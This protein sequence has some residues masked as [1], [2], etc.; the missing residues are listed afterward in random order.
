D[1]M[2][3]WRPNYRTTALVDGRYSIK[4]YLDSVKK[5]W[6]DY[7]AQGGHPLTAF[8]HFCYHQPFTRQAVKGHA[9]LAREGEISTELRDAQ[10]EGTLDYNRVIGNSYTASLYVGLISLLDSR[11]DDLS[12]HRVGFF[13]YGSGAVS[14]LFAGVIQPGYR[15]RTHRDEHH[16]DIAARQPISYERYYELHE[17]PED[18]DGG[19]HLREVATPGP[20]RYAGVVN[21][22]RR[23]EATGDPAPTEA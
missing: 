10:L 20:F 5:A 1:V 13:S 4:I 15:A 7:Q 12:G 3:F 21:H 2:D 11:T 6:R 17:R 18:V 23:Y 16:A 22:E 9:Q 19:E 14:E 8:D